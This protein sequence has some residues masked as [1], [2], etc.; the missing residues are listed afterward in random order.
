VEETM[1]NDKKDYVLIGIRGFNITNVEKDSQSKHLLTASP[2]SDLKIGRTMFFMEKGC[3]FQHL[4]TA[5][6]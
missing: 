1:P 4:H 5:P 6:M 3:Q 2:W